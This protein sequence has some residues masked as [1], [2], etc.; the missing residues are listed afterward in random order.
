MTRINPAAPSSGSRIDYILAS[1]DLALRATD[2]CVVSIPGLATDH[3]LLFSSFS[4][5]MLTKCVR[6]SVLRKALKAQSVW[7]YEVMTQESWV[8]FTKVAED[9]VTVDTAT[10]SLGSVGCIS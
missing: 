7:N 5:G 8:Q 3:R 9:F 10:G 6:R 2:S 4:L 1:T